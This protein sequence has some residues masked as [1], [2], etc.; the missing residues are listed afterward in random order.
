VDEA[1]SDVEDGTSRVVELVGNGEE[2]GS[3]EV[4]SFIMSR[5]PKASPPSIWLLGVP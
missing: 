2:E 5:I 4:T 1:V 3:D